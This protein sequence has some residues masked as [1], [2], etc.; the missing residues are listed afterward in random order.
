MGGRTVRER[1]QGRELKVFSF[2]SMALLLAAGAAGMVRERASLAD[3]VKGLWV[4]VISRDALI[5]D[6]FGL[7]GYAS[8][9]L[10]AV[11]VMG[12]GLWLLCREKVKFT[13]LTMAAVFINVGY[14]LWGKNPVNI[15]PILVGTSAYALVHGSRLSR[16]IYT[17]FFGTSLA[18]LVTELVFELPYGRKMNLLV[19]IAVGILIGFILPAL[20]VHTASM[21]MGYNLFNVGF[22]AGILAFVVVCVLK[23]FGIESESVL[24]WREGRPLWIVVGLFGYFALTFLYGLYLCGGRAEGLLKVWKHP[25]RAVADFVLMEGP[26]NTLMNMAL[27]GALCAAYICLIGGDFSGPVVGAI[28]TAF[29][30][31][32]FGAHVRNYAPVL[33]GVYLSTLLNRFEPTTPGVQLAAAFAVGLAPI[34]GRFGVIAGIVAGMLHT[35]IVM[36]TSQM[37]GGLNLYNNGFS[38]G[39]VAIIMV[40]AI[41]SFLMEYGRRKRRDTDA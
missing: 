31:S 6:Y 13:G 40:P 26:G 9:F 36:C 38:A 21:H 20:S 24:I 33:A 28:L 5:T 3:A 2:C 16:Y 18:P 27:V 37:Y 12:M 29:G 30:F 7:A 22:S 19:A 10:N 41:E 11:L 25:G 1:L 32:A 17:G 15:L 14:A 8:A 35:A 4:I 23:S 39:W 34:A